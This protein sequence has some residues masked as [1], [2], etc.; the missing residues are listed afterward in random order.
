MFQETFMPR[1][2]LMGLILVF[3]WVSALGCSEGSPQVKRGEDPFKARQKTQKEKNQ[4]QFMMPKE[5]K[6]PKKDG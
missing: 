2:G 1:I 3:G 6:A 5:A 4:G